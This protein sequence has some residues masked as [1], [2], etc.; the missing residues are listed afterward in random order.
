MSTDK[1][2]IKQLLTTWEET[3]KKGQLTLWLLVAL[4]D[5]PRYMTEVRD[6][7]KTKSN[8]NITCEEQSVYRALRKFYD[9]EIVDFELRE[10]NNGP[11]RKYYFLTEIGEELLQKFIK[12][13]IESM[14]TSEI[15]NLFLKKD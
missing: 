6:F 13:N 3:Y 4:R 11:S 7:I 2:Y 12:R 15:S 10:G 9:L 5:T 14:Y 8:G 1:N